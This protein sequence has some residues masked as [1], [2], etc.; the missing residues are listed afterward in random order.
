[1][2][3]PKVAYVS[4]RESDIALTL[5]QLAGIDHTFERHMVRSE[6]EVIEAVKDADVVISE[7]VPMGSAAI[8]AM[9]G[10]TA[11]VSL[12]HGFN[13]ID[14]LAATEAGIMVVNCAGYCSDE[15]ANH[16]ILFVL[17][18]SKRLVQLNTL[19]REGRWEP[20][21]PWTLLP[22]PSVY[23]QTLG[24]IGLG[25]IGRPTARKAKVFGLR[26]IVYDPYLPPWVADEYEVTTVE[27]MEELA[28]ASDYVSMHV[29]LNDGTRGLAGESL[30]RAMKP[31]AYFINTC[32]GPTHNEAALIR[33]L[34]EGQI[35]GA[36]LDVFEQEPT[37]DDNPLLAMD[38]V[39]VTPHSAGTSDRS[40]AA[41]R[42]RLGEE[43]ARILRGVYPMS[44]ANPDVLRKIPGRGPA[45]AS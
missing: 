19:V 14:D 2:G 40:N 43:T 34:R 27:T 5:D 44:I 17:A 23:G 18:C 1:M 25:N 36:A 30:F 42:S 11:I 21:T 13:H 35:A 15:V 9:R 28:A 22:M 7:A 38:N 29:P 41:G 37:P 31:T 8:E 20:Q 6:G 24:L 32:R 12:G 39:I 45:T 3:K 33:A 4:S 16:T 10:A 26:V